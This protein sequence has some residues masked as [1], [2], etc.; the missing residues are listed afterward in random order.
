MLTG[1]K[2]SL[3]DTEQ[4][5]HSKRATGQVRRLGR[6]HAG[7]WRALTRWHTLAAGAQA[8]GTGGPRTGLELPSGWLACPSLSAVLEQLR[9]IAIKVP[10]P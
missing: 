8:A 1:Q 2:R 5:T 7:A 4:A 6:P 3:P 9:V 10:L